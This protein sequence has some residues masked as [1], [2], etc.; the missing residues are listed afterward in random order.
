MGGRRRGERPRARATIDAAVDRV[1]PGRAGIRHHYDAGGA[2]DRQAADDA[3]PPI[4]RAFGKP[5]AVLD[6]DLD[7]DIPGEPVATATNL[8][9]YLGYGGCDHAARHRIDGGLAG[10][11]RQARPR[12]RP[13]PLAGPEG[14][15][16]AGRAG[17]HGR[18]HQR[19]VGDVGIVAGVLD[20]ARGRGVVVAPRERQR[21]CRALSARQR[22][23]DRVRKDAG[24]QRRIGGR[25]G[26]GRTG[27]GSPAA[28]AAALDPAAVRG[29]RRGDGRMSWPCL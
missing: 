11:H 8:V 3:E 10:R 19:A 21:K 27:A 22:D 28:A 18:Q 15:A 25:G 2:E 16:A 17:P 7:L 26:G 6:A 14:D 9:C 24:E 13:D 5:R 1:D 12:H 20:D 23:L 29:D 4:E